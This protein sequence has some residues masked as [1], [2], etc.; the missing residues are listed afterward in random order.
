MKRVAVGAVVAEPASATVRVLVIDDLGAE[1]QDASGWGTATILA[2]LDK[3]YE[4]ASRTL[5]TTNLTGA[6]LVARYGSDGGRLLDRMRETGT[7]VSLAGE[8][9]R[10]SV[11]AA[12]CL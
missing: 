1:P 8:S 11:T 6:Q 2:I 7:W 10:K 5:V 4:S 9:M 3:R 12:E